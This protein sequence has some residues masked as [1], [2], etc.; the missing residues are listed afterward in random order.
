[1]IT[2]Y[3]DGLCEPYNPYGVATFGFCIYKDGE[4]ASVGSGVVGEGLGMSN[5]VAEYTALYRALTEILNRGWEN[6]EV[7]VK[8]DSKLLVNQMNGLWRAR[9]GLYYETF[10]KTLKLTRKFHK[11]SFVW[12]PREENKE[13]DSLSR[14]AYEEYCKKKCVGAKYYD[15]ATFKRRKTGIRR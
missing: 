13:A 12:I 10:L 6:E 11:I 15:D 9:G 4:K 5:N 8:S 2:V 14:Q 7:T 3:I 1:M